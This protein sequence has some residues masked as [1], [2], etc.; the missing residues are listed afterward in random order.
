[1]IGE[2]RWHGSPSLF[3]S[4][5]YCFE[6]RRTPLICSPSPHPRADLQPCDRQ[7]KE[8]GEN[9]FN[10]AGERR[11]PI[12]T[13]FC[14]G[15][16]EGKCT[17]CIVLQHSTSE[18]PV[19]QFSPFFPPDRFEDAVNP[20]HNP[21]SSISHNLLQLLGFS[22]SPY[23]LL[24]TWLANGTRLA[25]LG[26]GRGGYDAWVDRTKHLAGQTSVSRASEYISSF[27]HVDAV[28]SFPANE[29]TC[30]WYRISRDKHEL[31]QLD[32]LFGPNQRR[33]RCPCRMHARGR[34]FADTDAPVGMEGEE[35]NMA[36]SR[37]GS[38]VEFHNVKVS[39]LHAFH[40]G[41]FLLLWSLINVCLCENAPVA[42]WK[43]HLTLVTVLS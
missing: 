23:L 8:A 33:R 31:K 2:E 11:S 29:N 41:K 14:G 34:R 28:G 22:P 18:K 32:K 39:V 4:H 24:S 1:M 17:F 9:N 26:L 6:W 20:P 16:I 10:L 38:C 40:K 13:S 19:D 43:C 36:R 3:N 25:C 42:R 27:S 35:E 21:I 37:A 7:E 15:V 12:K 30:L 5:C